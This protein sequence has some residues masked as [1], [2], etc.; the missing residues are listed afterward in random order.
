MKR[1]AGRTRLGWR[2]LRGY[3]RG[4]S[5]GITTSAAIGALP[6]LDNTLIDR[7][8]AF[9]EWANVF[10]EPELSVRSAAEQQAALHTLVELDAHGY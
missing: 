9:S 10:V 4:A 8:R 2:H 7:D 1:K 3:A 5:R 6:D